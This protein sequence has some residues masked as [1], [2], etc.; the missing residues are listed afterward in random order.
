MSLNLDEIERDFLARAEPIPF[1]NSRFQN[2]VF[3]AGTQDSPQRQYRAALL[4]LSD[5]IRAVRSTET[6]LRRQAVKLRQAEKR[7]AAAADPD[8]RELAEIDRDEITGGLAYTRKLY[9]DALAEIADL[10]ALVQA[11]P[12]YTRAEFEQAEAA[13]FVASLVDQVRGRVGAIESLDA[14]TKIGT[15]ALPGTEH[16]LPLVEGVRDQVVAQLKGPS[17]EG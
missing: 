17:D 8:E 11:H 16:L 4:R 15:P 14:I 9:E 7:I 12:A 13:H 3:V 1:G 10:H 2:V 6:E 5:R